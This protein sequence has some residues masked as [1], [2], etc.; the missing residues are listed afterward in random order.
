MIHVKI[1]AYHLMYQKDFPWNIAS[2]SEIYLV[3][4]RERL[5]FAS[6]G[7]MET[8]YSFGR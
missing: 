3:R 4:V 7:E 6:F 5:W 8:S 2:G 1:C